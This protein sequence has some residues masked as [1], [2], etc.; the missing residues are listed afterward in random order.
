M[1]TMKQV[2]GADAL[3]PGAIGG[4]T[5]QAERRLAALSPK[6]LQLDGRT[7]PELLAYVARFSELVAFYGGGTGHPVVQGK[8]N[9]AQYHPLL[10]MATVATYPGTTLA[11]RYTA[12]LGP[13]S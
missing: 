10:L 2:D 4:G 7:L 11:A 3:P 6:L 9:L 1:A 13:L 8:W 12:E 5:S